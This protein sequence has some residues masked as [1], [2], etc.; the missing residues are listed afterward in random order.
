MEKAI[1]ENRS[2]TPEDL[3]QLIKENYGRLPGVKVQNGN[4]A[5]LEYK[6]LNIYRVRAIMTYDDGEALQEATLVKINS[7][8]YI[9]NIK[10]IHIHF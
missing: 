4:T 10:P 9:S 7:Q 3:Q 8:W 1:A 2:L 6:K 5:K